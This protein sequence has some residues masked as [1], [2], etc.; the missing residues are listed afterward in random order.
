[1]SRRW[2]AAFFRSERPPFRICIQKERQL[3]LYKV[4]SLRGG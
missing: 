2:V 3:D 4:S 1:M